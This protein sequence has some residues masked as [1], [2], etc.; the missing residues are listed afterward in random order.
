MPI[1]HSNTY[2]RALLTAR[3]CHGGRAP[4]NWPHLEHR[5]RPI[6]NVHD[7]LNGHVLPKHRS[8]DLTDELISVDIKGIRHFVLVLEE[9]VDQC[10]ELLG[11][12]L[13]WQLQLRA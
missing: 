4:A 5:L 9:A 6:E 12:R 3:T 2:K 8:S 11:R 7:F 13:V 1:Q 10:F